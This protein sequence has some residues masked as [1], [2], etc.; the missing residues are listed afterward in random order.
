[1]TD[2]TTP[3]NPKPF[4]C[5]KCSIYSGEGSCKHHPKTPDPKGEPQ[6]ETLATEPRHGDAAHA[7]ECALNGKLLG[8][9][10][11]QNLARCYRQACEERD[12]LVANGKELSD[13]CAAWHD[14]HGAVEAERDAAR[15]KL[16]TALEDAARL[17]EALVEWGEWITR[18]GD[19]GVIVPSRAAAVAL[20]CSRLAALTPDTEVSKS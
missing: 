20:E 16:T 13:A 17:R 10:W 11:Y 19:S 3:P 7:A 2:T 14:R 8:L 4:V 6:P 1:M 12:G 9:P 15:H 18:N 5:S